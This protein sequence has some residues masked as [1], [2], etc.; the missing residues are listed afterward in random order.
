MSDDSTI[1][2]GL[3]QILNDIHDQRQQNTTIYV[4]IG[5]SA[6]SAFQNNTTGVWSMDQ[7]NNQQY[8]QFLKSL[9]E[10]LPFSPLHIIL[11]DPAL[12]DPP[13]ITWDM[14]KNNKKCSDIWEEKITYSNHKISYYIDNLSN[15]SVYVL[16]KP[17]KYYPYT[18]H[19]DVSIDIDVFF[20]QLNCDSI[21]NNWFTVVNDF[22]GRIMAVIA[23]IHDEY[24]GDHINH[25]IYG[26]GARKDGGCNFDLTAPECNFV[27]DITDNYGIKVFNPFC[28]SNKIDNEM[29]ESLRLLSTIDYFGEKPK[30]DYEIVMAQI[31]EFMKFK[32]RFILYDLMSLIR[33]FGML[34][35][36]P[37]RVDLKGIVINNL[38]IKTKHKVNLLERFEQKK[39]SEILSICLDIL[40]KEIGDHI[41][42]VYKEKTRE[43]VEHT[44]LNML[45]CNDPYKWYDYIKKLL[46]NFDEQTGKKIEITF[47]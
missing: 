18:N 38:Y 3:S 30:R 17:V 23:M 43:I 19:D 46:D 27:Y 15:I 28:E 5:C 2:S 22:S 41:F 25:V 24:L 31:G 16:R 35:K 40:K 44:V 9:K 10:I 39:Y 34:T 8:P 7:K 13:F 11:I 12:E 21:K 33:Q 20:Q 6:P 26:I 45:L 1:L 4:S 14:S 36:D 29:L 42:V 47:I 37:E 32:R